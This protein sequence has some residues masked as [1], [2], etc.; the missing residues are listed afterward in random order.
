MDILRFRLGFV[1]PLI[2]RKDYAIR[3][4]GGW[5]RVVT[6]L[7]S[8]QRLDEDYFGPIIIGFIE[9]LSERNESKWTAKH[10]WFLTDVWDLMEDNYMTLRTDMNR[11]KAQYL[12]PLPKALNQQDFRGSDHQ[13]M[14]L[15]N[16]D[17]HLAF[18]RPLYVVHALRWGNIP[19]KDIA[20]RFLKHGVVPFRTF[21]KLDYG[22]KAWKETDPAGINYQPAKVKLPYRKH[23]YK[24][25]V[26]DYEEAEKRRAKILSQP[27]ARAAWLYDGI[28]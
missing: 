14:I 16:K 9:T 10:K 4:V 22:W 3:G 20:S 24:F 11:T 8:S 7:S 6:T 27:H 25:T 17:V 13:Y 19:V 5:K 23:G 12:I 26:E 2:S 21:I 1:L 18:I 15:A 28:I